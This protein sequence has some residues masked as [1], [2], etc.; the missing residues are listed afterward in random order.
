VQRSIEILIGKLVT[1]EEF[2]L[3]FLHD[4]KA[5]LELA[6]TWGIALS[7]YE[8]RALLSTD[9][10]LWDRVADELDVRLQKASLRNGEERS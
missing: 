5:T 6:E 3:A 9:R 7:P 10:G 4:P 1:D 2:R 8:V